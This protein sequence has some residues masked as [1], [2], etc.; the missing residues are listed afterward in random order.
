MFLN[1]LINNKTRNTRSTRVRILARGQPLD[2]DHVSSRFGGSDL[3]CSVRIGTRWI[4]ISLLCQES[5]YNN[6]EWIH[7]SLKSRRNCYRPGGWWVRWS[8]ADI[9]KNRFI[10]PNNLRKKN[11]HLHERHSWNKIHYPRKWMRKSC[12]QTTE[13]SLLQHH[14]EW[15]N[16]D[17]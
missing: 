6:T 10:N 15:F 16:M 14:L 17:R 5:H 9:H 7:C 1:I 4:F 8:Q 3:C 2:P 12:F 11:L 13:K